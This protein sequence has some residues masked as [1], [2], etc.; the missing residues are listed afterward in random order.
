LSGVKLKY[1]FYYMIQNNFR[2]YSCR[3]HNPDCDIVK[4]RIGPGRSINL[5]V[6]V[7]GPRDGELSVEY[8]SGPNYHPESALSKSYSRH[9]PSPALV[10]AK[11][12][13]D[14]K[15]CLDWY[16]ALPETD[17]GPL[18]APVAAGQEP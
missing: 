17:K 12:Q 16:L 1:Y 15:D 10:P 5:V 4:K 3:N 18:P 13:A 2:L 11:Y 6:Y 9:W 7:S 14:I 8:Y